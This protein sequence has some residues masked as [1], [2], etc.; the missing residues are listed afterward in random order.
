MTTT[1]DAEAS[2][3]YFHWPARDARGPRNSGYYYYDAILPRYK[4]VLNA[5]SRAVNGR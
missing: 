5:V 4:L 1:T 3:N 2:I